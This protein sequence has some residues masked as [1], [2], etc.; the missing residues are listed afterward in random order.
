MESFRRAKTQPKVCFVLKAGCPSVKTCPSTRRP[1]YFPIRGGAAVAQA[2]NVA[3]PGAA[4]EH[5]FSPSAD[6]AGKTPVGCGTKES[7]TVEMTNEEA[8]ISEGTYEGIPDNMFPGQSVSGSSD[9]SDGSLPLQPQPLPRVNEG[10][11]AGSWLR[12]GQA[13]NRCEKEIGRSGVPA[14]ETRRPHSQSDGSLGEGASSFGLDDR[15]KWRSGSWRGTGGEDD[16]EE[17]AIPRVGSVSDDGAADGTR[18]SSFLPFT[19]SGTGGGVGHTGN[20]CSRTRRPFS[21]VA[22][23]LPSPSSSSA[24]SIT[25]PA[26]GADCEEGVEISFGNELR[27]N[28][29]GIFAAIDEALM[30]ARGGV[31]TEKGIGGREAPTRRIG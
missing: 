19:Q 4:R 3:V 14:G 5:F 7:S 11:P 23:R 10:G 21:S 6:S 8:G 9:T 20:H 2:G 1:S 24:E 28:R 29:G 30:F 15:E 31:P 22:G 13:G 27:R 12:N 25:S 17:W 16:G 18:G 26:S